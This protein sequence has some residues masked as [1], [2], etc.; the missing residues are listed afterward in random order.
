MKP[1]GKPSPRRE[2]THP[3]VGLISAWFKAGGPWHQAFDPIPFPTEHPT[4]HPQGLVKIGNHFYIST[5]DKAGKRSSEHQN[6]YVYKL[7]FDSK[8]LRLTSVAQKRLSIFV[9]GEA[10]REF[11]PGGMDFDPL[12]NAIII[13]LSQYR[14]H[15]TTTFLALDPETLSTKELLADSDHYGSIICVGDALLATTWHAESLRLLTQ[16]D[17][18]DLGKMP[19]SYQ[20]CKFIHSLE[21]DKHTY[22]YALCGGLHR[23]GSIYWKAKLSLPEYI[24]D[25]FLDLIEIQVDSTLNKCKINRLGSKVVDIID[26]LPLTHNTLAVEQV[27][28]DSKN[29]HLRFYFSPHDNENTKLFAYDT[30]LFEKTSHGHY[31]KI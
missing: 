2:S 21:K 5:V 6:G 23:K 20:D 16:E 18:Y 31:K 1:L 30:P 25:G 26:G 28:I 3:D 22:I 8:K 11:H 15:S 4:H 19:A 12:R 24:K 7:H 9:E 13:P 27:K 17:R 10:Q 29:S 14:A